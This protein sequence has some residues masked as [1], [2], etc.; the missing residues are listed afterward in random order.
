[1]ERGG[2]IKA[3]VLTMEIQNQLEKIGNHALNVS[4]ASRTMAQH[5]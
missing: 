5:G 2:N 1:M 4:E 3:E